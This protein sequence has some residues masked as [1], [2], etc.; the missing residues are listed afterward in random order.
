MKS[1]MTTISSARVY[2]VIQTYS[3]KRIFIELRQL[4]LHPE[5]LVATYRSE[6]KKR[7]KRD[8]TGDSK[9]WYFL[10]CVTVAKISINQQPI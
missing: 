10:L 6:A 8:T 1:K 4:I 5:I 9:G 2:D 7:Y 3:R